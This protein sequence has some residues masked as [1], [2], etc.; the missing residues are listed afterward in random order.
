MAVIIT[1]KIG[2]KMLSLRQTE[3]RGSAGIAGSFTEWE[4]CDGKS[5]YG[6]SCRRCVELP[7]QNENYT[8]SDSTKK[9]QTITFYSHKRQN[10]KKRADFESNTK[11]KSDKQNP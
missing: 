6:H 9:G 11:R 5:N 10:M 8:F 7:T 4:D 2:R 1:Q 3:P